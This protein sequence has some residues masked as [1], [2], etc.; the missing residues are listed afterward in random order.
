MALE[1][2][3]LRVTLIKAVVAATRRS[4]KLREGQ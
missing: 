3:A 2:G 4:Q 1:E